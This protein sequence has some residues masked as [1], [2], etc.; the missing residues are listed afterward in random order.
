MPTFEEDLAQVKALRAKQSQLNASAG[1]DTTYAKTFGDGVWDKIRAARAER[2]IT[3]LQQ[4]VGDT[5]GQLVSDNPAIRARMGADVNPL[6]VDAIT[7]KQ[8][9]QN[10]NTLG[11]LSAF[12]EDTNNTL[13]GAIGAE[14]NK[15]LARAAAK[16]A[17]AKVAKEES[18][19]IIEQINMRMEQERLNLQKAD[20]ANKKSITL[21]NGETVELT[22]KEYL[23]LYMKD[24]AQK[25]LSV[26]AQNKIKDL[27]TFVRDT[28]DV[29]KNLSS[30]GL[31]SDIFSGVTGPIA[32]FFG[33]YGAGGDTRAAIDRYGS[34]VKNLTYGS[35]LSEGE[36]KD[37]NKWLPGSGQ[38]EKSN[39]IRLTKIRDQKFGELITNLQVSGFS[40]QE[41]RDYLKQMGISADE[42]TLQRYGVGTQ[43]SLN[44]SLFNNQTESA[45][46]LVSLNP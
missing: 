27:T 3:A 23:E 46:E 43:G 39:I 17:E 4:G 31:L 40:G 13:E 22:D 11:T 6:E 42:V 21:P 1:A 33:Q 44:K 24:N 19:A 2:G 35:A 32:Q 30:G 5:M 45:Y 41:I 26:S 15:L 7:A 20:K 8:R 25:D 9:A 29:G 28:D 38:Q 12:E 16:E 10:V 36:I 18:D 37:A 34:K 14:T